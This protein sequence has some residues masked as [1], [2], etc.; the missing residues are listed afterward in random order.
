MGSWEA[1]EQMVSSVEVRS[2]EVLCQQSQLLEDGREES[3]V[4][5]HLLA[6]RN[7][8]IAFLD[9]SSG[10]FAGAQRGAGG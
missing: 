6:A 5:P 3:F 7:G 9:R 2:L 8:A 10:R 1:G 4:V